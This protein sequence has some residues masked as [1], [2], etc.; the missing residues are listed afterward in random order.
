MRP[1]PERLRT[2]EEDADASVP[3]EGQAAEGPR[4]DFCPH[5]DLNLPT[6]YEEVLKRFRRLQ[7][8]RAWEMMN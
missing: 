2:E 7:G 6:S 8:D 3:K 4:F 1:E 5:K